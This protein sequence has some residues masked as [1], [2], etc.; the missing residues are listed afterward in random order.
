METIDID[1]LNNCTQ[2]NKERVWVVMNLFKKTALSLLVLLSFPFEVLAYSNY[3]IPGGESIGIEIK[4]EGILVVGFY[5]VNGK[6]NKG[7]PNIKVGDRITRVEGSLV[8]SVKRMVDLMEEHVK[9]GKVTLTVL[10][11]GKDKEIDLDLTYEDGNYKTGLYVKDEISGIGTLTYIDPETKIYGALGHNIVEANTNETVEVRTG[12]IFRSTITSIDRSSSGSPGGKNAKFYS[13]TIYGNIEKNSETG[14]YG[15]YTIEV[16]D[17]KALKVATIEEIEEGNAK[18]Y[19]V[20]EGDTLEEFDIE[21]TKVDEK[22]DIKN[23]YFKV[24]DKK[25]LEKTGGIV[26]GM[27]GSPIIQNDKIIGAVTHVVISNPSSGYG[28]SIINML[29]EGERQN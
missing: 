4:S 17:K 6:F 28:I 15:K 25:L 3:I 5:K 26:Q 23:I 9:E 19:T 13:S 20:L 21:I 18:I 1:I 11:N 22:S 12:S 27:S 10:R 24:T 7:T 29:E 14:I 2:N 8:D 16:P